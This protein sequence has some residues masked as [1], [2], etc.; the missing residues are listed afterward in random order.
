MHE[1]SSNALRRVFSALLDAHG[2][3]HWWPGDSP[4]EIM[5]GAILT[6]NTS[7]HNA[8]RAIARLRQQNALTPQILLDTE[9]E[10]LAQ[11]LRPCGYFRLKTRRLRNFC[12]W[13]L[14]QG[15]LPGLQQRNTLTLRLALL[16]VNGIGPE[17][18]D[19]ILLYV[20][21]R[22]VFVIDAY[23]R[24]LFSRFDWITGNEDY[25]TL[26]GA[27]ERALDA[28][29]ACYGEY[30]ALI[31]AHGK[32]SC[33]TQPRCAHCCLARQCPGAKLT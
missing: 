20:F 29:A 31:V 7:W 6:Q 24:R 22:P 8:E 32:R 18:A 26:R 15:A 14:A 11:W 10:L 33:R 17:T 13:Y 28:D 16:S 25:E 1:I 30:H 2:P 3:Q 12:A 27:L 21:E 4:F 23:A 19:A 9:P 5:V